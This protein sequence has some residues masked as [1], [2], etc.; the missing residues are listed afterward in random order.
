MSK[1]SDREIKEEILNNLD[2][3]KGYIVDFCSVV[4]EAKNKEE[5]EEKALEQIQ[6]GDIEIDNII[7]ND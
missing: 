5:A 6:Q 2:N 7:E 4:V 1:K 3:V